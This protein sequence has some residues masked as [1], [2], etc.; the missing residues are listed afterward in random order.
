M[1][2]NTNTSC[3]ARGVS[4]EA[5]LCSI[6]VSDWRGGWHGQRRGH[7]HGQRHM[8][9]WHCRDIPETM[10]TSLWMTR[11]SCV[12]LWTSGPVDL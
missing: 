4:Q 9:V 1:W 7:G 8:V 6:W 12:D 3:L 2:C 11:R 5:L 10:L